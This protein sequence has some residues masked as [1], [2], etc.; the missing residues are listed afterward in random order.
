M[1]VAQVF[2]SVYF[3][4]WSNK[5]YFRPLVFSSI[6]LLLGNT[7]YALAYDLDS[8]AVLLIGRLFCGLGSARA[9]NRRYISDCVPLKLR[10]QASAGFVSASALGMA[11]GPAL[12][13]LLQMNFKIYKITINEDTL[14]GWVMAL[15]WL[16]YLIWLWISFKE[17]DHDIEENQAPQEANPEPVQND[18]MEKGLA[19]P[20]LSNSEE[21]QN[22][23]DE[24]QECDVSEEGS[25]DSNKPVTSIGSAYRLLT[26]S[27]K[28]QLLIYF[29]LKYSMEILLSESSVITTFYFGWSTSAV[30]IFLACLG[31]TVLP[32]NVVVGSY[33]SNMFED[34]QILL[35]AEIMVCIGIFLSFHVLVPYSVPQYVCSA[36]ITFVS[37]EV[38]E[39]N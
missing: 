30:A 28:A 33:I 20:L 26:P 29:M 22:D 25:E 13:G 10:M 12:A 4:A 39:G 32:V 11:C 2:S 35:A 9:V 17:P 15:A 6:V 1:A 27:I 24:Y 21:K 3:S 37:A 14:P 19:Q 8:I 5:S 38:L 23:N 34:R 36:L 31:L 16:L 18:Q 7:L